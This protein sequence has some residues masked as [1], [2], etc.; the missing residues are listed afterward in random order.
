MTDIEISPERAA[1]ITVALQNAL[2]DFYDLVPVDIEQAESDDPQMIAIQNFGRIQILALAATM[3]KTFRIYLMISLLT[4]YSVEYGLESFG[5]VC[6]QI[7]EGWHPE[8]EKSDAAWDEDREF[9][10]AVKRKMSDATA[11]IDRFMKDAEAVSNAKV[12]GQ[13]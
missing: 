12:K 11:L 13:G 3:D 1:E 6:D 5:E 10:I 8:N 9:I 7:K 4:N 2:I